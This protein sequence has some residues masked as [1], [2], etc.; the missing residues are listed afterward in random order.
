MSLQPICA[1]PFSSHSSVRIGGSCEAY[2]PDS[3]EEFLLLLDRFYQSDQP[4]KVVG[5]ASN[6][7]ACDGEIRTKIIFTERLCSVVPILGG[8][9]MQTGAR[10]SRVIYQAAKENKALLPELIGV[11]GSLGGMVYQN[12]SCY[13]RELSEGF[14]RARLYDL[15]RR[16]VMEYSLDQMKFGYRDSILKHSNLVLLD[17]DFRFLEEEK[18]C[19]KTIREVT[20]KR[21][22]CAPEAPSLGSV[23]LKHEGISI[24]LLL[25]RLSQKGR[26]F[27]Q[28]M[29]SG[30]H[31]GILVNLGG[32]TYKDFKD[33][34]A[35][36]SRLIFIH[37]GFY[38]H[39][40]IE[41][42]E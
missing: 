18:D 30:R 2:F 1:F 3:T 12:A 16:E 23:F 6:I 37:H 9:R 33:A 29:V 11:P 24:G 14:L 35:E 34:I 5:R 7:L 25:D 31:A 32:A 41:F 4:F 10:M 39:C 20:K 13:G 27:G 40:E 22:M 15:N 38:P 28:L 36:L 42:L 19:M 21:R 17:A 8:V 26:R